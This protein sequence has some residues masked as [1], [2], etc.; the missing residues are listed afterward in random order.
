MRI[1]NTKNKRLKGLIY[2]TLRILLDLSISVLKSLSLKSV[3]S[4]ADHIGDVFYL[5]TPG[6]RQRVLYHLRIALGDEKSEDTIRYI[7]KK[8]TRNLIRD[9]LE[10]VYLSELSPDGI[11]GRI[12]LEGKEYLDEALAQ[13]NGVISLTA[14]FG[15]FMIMGAKFASTGN[16]FNTIVKDPTEE[17]YPGWGQ[18]VRDQMGYKTI[19]LHPRDLCGRKILKA[20]RNNEIVCMITDDNKPSGG[21]FVDFFGKKAATAVGPAVL[22]LKIG[23]P[24]LPMFII[25]QPDNT[26]KIVIEPALK[27]D[28]S[29]NRDIDIL[30]ITQAFTNTIETYIRRHPDHWNW[31]RRRWKT[32]PRR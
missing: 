12:T 24:I 30:R 22:S 6:Y 31:S 5:F 25:R 14:H 10:L 20:L 13:G 26:H 23:A 32:Q 8:A 28:L 29:G 18:G 17:W 27:V 11:S 3:Y 16:S 1:K 9:S 4:L 15:N 7:A 2:S 19:P 21:V